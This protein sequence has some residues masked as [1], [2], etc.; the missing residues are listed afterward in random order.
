MEIEQVGRLSQAIVLAQRKVEEA[1]EEV[2][3]AIC[4][5]LDPET[6]EPERFGLIWGSGYWDD[7]L[8]SPTL[9]DRSSFWRGWEPAAIRD[10]SRWAKQALQN[11]QVDS[12]L[13]RYVKWA[14]DL[15]AVLND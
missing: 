7:F 6:L 4:L 13:E 14:N 10:F 11:P 1:G 15:E 2:H 12:D 8:D 9:Y 5:F 3:L